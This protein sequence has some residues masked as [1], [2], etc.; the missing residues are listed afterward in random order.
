MFLTFARFR[1]GLLIQRL[2]LNRLAHIGLDA[3]LLRQ[4]AATWKEDFQ[5]PQ[6]IF[7]GSILF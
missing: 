7:Q 1:L 3:A 6:D 4:F 2:F 5:I